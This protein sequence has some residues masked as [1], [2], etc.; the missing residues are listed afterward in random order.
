M[1]LPP[2]TDRWQGNPALAAETWIQ[3]V[4]FHTRTKKLSVLLGLG[5]SVITLCLALTV[6]MAADA[7][8][9]LSGLRWPLALA[10]YGLTALS[11]FY[12]CVLP[13]AKRFV[14]SQTAVDFERS[15]PRLC[16]QLLSAV[17]LSQDDRS[18]AGDSLEFRSR[19]QELV[20]RL[21]KGSNVELLLPARLPTQAMFLAVFTASALLGA[22]FWPALQLPQRAARILLP[23]RDLG[24]LGRVVIEITRPVPANKVVARGDVAVVEA[25]IQGPRP[26]DVWLEVRE[27]NS[28]GQ[29]LSSSSN[30][31]RRHAMSQRSRN[32]QDSS[33][34]SNTFYFE[35]TLP[36][37]S[38]LIEYRIAASGTET[39]WFGLSTLPRPSVTNFTFEIGFPDY[40]GQS[41]VEIARPD[42]N[43][44]VPEGA[45]VR[46]QIEPDVALGVAELKWIGA[47]TNPALAQTSRLQTDPSAESAI[48]MTS[49]EAQYTADYRLYLQSVP[50]TVI[51]RDGGESEIAL[52]NEFDSAFAIEVQNDLPPVVQWRQP[53]SRELIT[54]PAQVLDLMAE[55]ED[56]YPIAEVQVYL[57]KEQADWEQAS[58]PVE[59]SRFT[60]KETDDP[61]NARQDF[62]SYQATAHV[63]LDLLPLRLLAGESLDI[64]IQVRDRAG[65]V[66]DSELLNVQV[67]NA[68]LAMLP[69]ATE[70]FR[71]DLAVQL[72]QLSAYAQ[73][74]VEMLSEIV[75]GGILHRDH[76]VI[77]RRRS[78]SSYEGIAQLCI[79][80]VQTALQSLPSM[81]NRSVASEVLDA[82]LVVLNLQHN[83]A[84][85][86][87]REAHEIEAE[88][89]RIRRLDFEAKLPPAD[90]QRIADLLE[91]LQD[92]SSG[93]A[94]NFRLLLAR[95]AIQRHA[96]QMEE[97]GR[98]FGVLS[99]EQG[100][101]AQAAGRQHAVLT[102]QLLEVQQSMLDTLPELH[103]EVQF[104]FKQTLEIVARAVEQAERINAASDTP[105]ILQAAK[106]VG[107]MLEQTDVSLQS[108]PTTA[109]LWSDAAMEIRQWV[110]YP[111]TQLRS[112]A[113]EYDANPAARSSSFRLEYIDT[114]R[115]LLREATFGDRMFATDLGN[116]LRAANHVLESDDESL[117]P[118]PVLTELGDAIDTLAVGSKLMDLVSAWIELLNAER[119]LQDTKSL[120]QQN[121]RWDYCW[122]Q[123]VWLESQLELVHFPTDVTQSLVQ[124]RQSL[125]MQRLLVHINARRT[126]TT[127]NRLNASVELN[128]IARQ[129][130]QVLMDA[131]PSMDAARATLLEYQ[132]KLSDLALR[133][134]RKVR[135]LRA[136]TDNLTSAMKRSEAIDRP[137]AFFELEDATTD[138]L[139][140][141]DLLRSL[142]VDTADTRD[143]LSR[144]Q[145]D[146]VRKLDSALA[147]V[148]GVRSQLEHAL[149][150]LEPLN[151]ARSQQ[152]VL[153]DASKSQG[154]A[155]AALE[156]LA[157]FFETLESSAQ[158]PNEDDPLAKLEQLK[159]LMS[160][161]DRA[162]MEAREQALNKAESLADLA[163][164]D[165]HEALA[166]LEK[167]LKSSIPM[168]LEMSEISKQAVGEALRQLQAA[169]D[170]DR[171]LPQQLEESDP[172]FEAAKDMLLDDLRLSLS[173]GQRL[174]EY[175]LGEAKWMAGAAR[176]AGEEARLASVHQQLHGAIESVRSITELDL[177]MAD[178][179]AASQNFASVLLVIGEE[180]Q[181][182]SKQ[183]VSQTEKSIHDNGA[184]LNNRRREMR[185][186]QRRI[187]QHEMRT[188]QELQRTVQTHLATADRELRQRQDQ[189]SQSQEV[190]ETHRKDAENQETTSASELA[191]RRIREAELS[192]S[193]I[194]QRTQEAVLEQAQLE[195]QL[196]RL[197]SILSGINTRSPLHLE[198]VNPTAEL[199]AKVTQVASDRADLARQ[200]LLTSQ[201]RPTIPEASADIL[202]S[203][204]R[205]H[206][207]VQARVERSLENLQR[208]ARH[209]ARLENPTT[210]QQLNDI[211]GALNTTLQEQVTQAAQTLSKSLSEASESNSQRGTVDQT[212]ASLAALEASQKAI[213]QNVELISKLLQGGAMGASKQPKTSDQEP[214]DANQAMDGEGSD[215]LTPEQKAQLLDELDQKLNS[216]EANL[217]KK[218]DNAQSRDGQTSEQTP[219]TLS[220]AAQELASQMSRSR[221]PPPPAPGAN[222]DVAMGTESQMANVEP[223]GESAVRV[224]D[225]DRQNGD[226]GQLREQSADQSLESR[227][228]ILLPEYQEQVD[229]YFRTVAER[230]QQ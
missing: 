81:E 48:W 115:K 197:D 205:Q 52:T 186:R 86:L 103:N 29:L 65:Q 210:S 160:P 207:D 15:D 206:A 158:D 127:S 198:S 99:D 222:S 40:S 137:G 161:E 156:Q 84:F 98:A 36:T 118:S 190:L 55:I 192:H 146:I 107:A 193:I 128:R 82:A 142:I 219:N 109:K 88:M 178:L 169:A 184:D 117:K 140:P 167:E 2:A 181:K 31:P 12:G 189:L 10:V 94:D 38:P 121:E 214:T 23:H 135:Q 216:A 174:T 75:R 35:S 153:E 177:P 194:A 215:V 182:S 163:A 183:F 69:S 114:Q 24:R 61:N 185:D 63:Q 150:H 17:E 66:T 226:W 77:L 7:T 228:V 96:A 225:V 54:S 14:P 143:L 224:I 59:V 134:A 46:L 19:T 125:D 227:R 229:A 129:L 60:P 171:S 92:H 22:S 20:A 172:S 212:R 201:P 97:L 83:I 87:Q 91:R 111:S 6:A 18:N 136:M 33:S 74:R 104:H 49:F 131:Q 149:D 132:P 58:L 130:D 141:I 217:G 95:D 44:T 101:S 170:I 25:R 45:T 93:L 70:A 223:Q 11:I 113:R 202:Q 220:E 64:K 62:P 122:N 213:E 16:G 34:V 120:F 123:W 188:T 57:R 8:W 195:Q 79:A 159:N 145:I 203:A 218:E 191:Q 4:A 138:S 5:I 180:L 53:T 173:I 43:L 21:V 133:A 187:D 199:T 144:E 110:G 9:Q 42:G 76:T 72:E 179:Q 71:A 102:R 175:L 108:S 151:Y 204:A 112:M 176:E 166:M 126:Q 13:L 56:L 89:L 164:M 67:S 208:A 27:L 119:H 124:L 90:T 168:Q 73:Q 68:N 139:W 230:G 157:K 116:T 47:A 51:T 154:D 26:K 1:Q 165:P 39:P 41:P 211:G 162:K 80:P 148:D 155:A 85:G 196:G 3:L 30:S 221:Q 100:S 152:S 105:H 209:E 147:I 32:E 28:N 200:L 78:D 50:Q 37:G 106:Q